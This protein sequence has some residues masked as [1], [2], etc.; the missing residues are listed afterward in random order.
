LQAGR[1]NPR[2][3]AITAAMPTGT[4]LVKFRENFPHRFFDVGIAESH[5]VTFAAGL[6]KG[7]LHP[8]VAIYST[9]LQRAYDQI[10]HDVCIQNLPVVFALD[11]SGI[12]AAD[13]ETHQGVFDISFLT[14]MP[15]MTVLAPRNAI[16]L[17][18]ML[19]FAIGLNAP[20]AIRY[21]KETVSALFEESRPA[22]ELGKWEILFAGSKIA[23]V[24]L[25]S[26]FE[27]CADL[28]KQLQE[29]GYE[30]SLINARFA[31]PICREM[32]ASLKDFDYIFT[33]E[34][35]ALIGG[36]GQFLA[37]EMNVH[38]FAAPRIHNFGVLDEFLPQGTR[39]EVLDSIGLGVDEIFW[40]ILE[41]IK[42]A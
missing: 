30:P 24:S 26:M 37:S 31:K 13:G 10:I 38:G 35:N 23:L 21:P 18:Q 36:F 25:G 32:L 3:I 16:E 22:I 2:V 9:F 17:A 8:V 42:Y 11:R 7:G 40:K 28:Y 34:E 20:V 29:K 1:E 27:K 12:V 19:K 39:E 15:N 6:A 33:F 14:Q 5:A 41:V 4:G